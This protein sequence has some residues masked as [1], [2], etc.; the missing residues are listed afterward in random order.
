VLVFSTLIGPAPRTIVETLYVAF[1]LAPPHRP[2]VQISP[3]NAVLIDILHSVLH[4]V[5]FLLRSQ[6]NRHCGNRSWLGSSHAEPAIHS[7]E[8]FLFNALTRALSV[9]WPWTRTITRTITERQPKI[10]FS[11]TSFKMNVMSGHSTKNVAV[12]RRC[13]RHIE[14]QEQSACE[15]LS[16]FV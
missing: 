8:R 5:D 14:V 4:G 15:M 6:Q 10:Q 3:S 2:I 13:E 11:E 9:S 16:T 7:K 1:L 12:M